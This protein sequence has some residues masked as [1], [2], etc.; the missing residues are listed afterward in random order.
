MQQLLGKVNP[1]V[2]A[3]NARTFDFDWLRTEGPAIVGSPAEVTQR[4]ADLSAMLHI[5]THLLYMDMGGMAP[6]ELYDAVDLF[7]AAV[8]PALAAVAV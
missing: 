6:A 4:I 8:I 1:A 7:G 2:P 3:H 5:S